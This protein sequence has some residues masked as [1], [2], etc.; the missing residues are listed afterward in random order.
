MHVIDAKYVGLQLV[1]SFLRLHG[2]CWQRRGAFDGR[3]QCLGR[4]GGARPT[5]GTFRESG[6]V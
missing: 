3:R 4:H 2:L 1:M 5:Q 6:G